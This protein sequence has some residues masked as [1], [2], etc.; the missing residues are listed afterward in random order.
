MRDSSPGT[1]PFRRVVRAAISPKPRQEVKANPRR[2]RHFALP[3]PA[4]H[5]TLRPL[6]PTDRLVEDLGIDPDDVEFDLI[7]EVASRSGHLPDNADRNPFWGKIET[8]GDFVRFVTL[9]PRVAGAPGSFNGGELADG[10]RPPEDG[11]A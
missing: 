7:D 2:G 8:V 3:R 10:E 11:H 5:A 4:E 6:R 9:Q 1:D